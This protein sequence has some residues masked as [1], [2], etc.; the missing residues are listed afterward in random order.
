VVDTRKG[1]YTMQPRGGHGSN[2]A[3]RLARTEIVRVH[4]MATIEATRI[5]PGAKGVQWRLSNRHP[6]LD[7]CTEHAEYGGSDGLPT[8]VYTVDELPEY[9]AHPNEICTLVP[10]MES[11][12]KVIDMLVE[13]YGR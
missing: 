6:K 3:R 10:V 2:P 1:V 7:I 5:T 9:P 8:G 13:E 12:E 11:R 4:G